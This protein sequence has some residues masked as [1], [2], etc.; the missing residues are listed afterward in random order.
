M[1]P[2]CFCFSLRKKG[3][4]NSGHNGRFKVRVFISLFNTDGGTNFRK[5]ERKREFFLTIKL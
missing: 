3:C 2:F 5:S 1:T 4:N